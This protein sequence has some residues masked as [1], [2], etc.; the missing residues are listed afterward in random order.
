MQSQGNQSNINEREIDTFVFCFF[1]VF[2][3][4]NTGTETDFGATEAKDN[5][6]CMLPHSVRIFPRHCSPLNNI[7]P[8][9]MHNL[10]YIPA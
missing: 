5:S 2:L 4:C 10:S 1:F 3:K 7:L 8:K 6:I 9:T